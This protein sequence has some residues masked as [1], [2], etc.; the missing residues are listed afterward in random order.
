MAGTLGDLCQ[1]CSAPFRVQLFYDD[2]F[3]TPI[4]ELKL[5]LF[6]R[7]QNLIAS[8]ARTF[9][10]MNFGAEDATPSIVPIQ[11]NLGLYEHGDVPLGPVDFDTGELPDIES[12]A[13]EAWEIENEIVGGIWDYEL[14]MK[15]LLSPIAAE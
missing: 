5:R 9:H 15:A 2:P 14:E 8:N 7:N 10:A 4:T 1:T 13:D 12:A 3:Q 6:D 11:Q